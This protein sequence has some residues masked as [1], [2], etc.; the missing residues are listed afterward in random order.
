MSNERPRKSE[1]Q[2]PEARAP[3]S[4]S[5]RYLFVAKA[6]FLSRISSA[7]ADYGAGFL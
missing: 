3:D 5:L 4:L 6:G 7:V 1:G 2:Q